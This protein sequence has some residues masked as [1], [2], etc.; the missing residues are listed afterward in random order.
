MPR[1]WSSFRTAFR[2]FKELARNQIP[3]D[4]AQAQTL[5][6]RWKSPEGEMHQYVVMQ[7]RQALLLTF[8]VTSPNALAESQRD[9]FQQIIQSFSAE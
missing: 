4:G 3:L 6:Y 1:P 9:Y 2:V 5:E 8:T 7:V